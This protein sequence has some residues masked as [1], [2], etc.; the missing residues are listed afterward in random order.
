MALYPLP[1]GEQHMNVLQPVLAVGIHRDLLLIPVMLLL[2][3][4]AEVTKSAPGDLL[5]VTRVAPQPLCVVWWLECGDS[6]R[7]WRQSAIRSPTQ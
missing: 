3:Y 2:G 1:V 7:V 6:C 4:W 5:Q